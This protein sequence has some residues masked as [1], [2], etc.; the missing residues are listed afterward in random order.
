M[1]NEKKIVVSAKALKA[2]REGQFTAA[3]K[4]YVE[5]APIVT[6]PAGLWKLVERAIPA[7]NGAPAFTMQICEFVIPKSDGTM[8]PFDRV[9]RSGEVVDTDNDVKISTYRAE[10]DF[11][12]SNGTVI[13]KGLVKQFAANA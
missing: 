7:K 13:P 12:C 4:V 10:R 3:E 11:T 1:A 9:F 6:I 8:E 2:L 5:D